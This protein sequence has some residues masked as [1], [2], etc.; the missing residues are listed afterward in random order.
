MQLF[1]VIPNKRRFLL[2]I[3][4]LN[5]YKE[6]LFFPITLMRNSL[7]GSTHGSLRSPRTLQSE[8]SVSRNAAM[9]TQK[10][11]GKD[12]QDSLVLIDAYEEAVSAGEQLQPENRV[13]YLTID[14]KSGAVAISRPEIR[15]VLDASGRVAT[16]DDDY[17]TVTIFHTDKEDDT[18][19][20]EVR[21]AL[22]RVVQVTKEKTDEKQYDLTASAEK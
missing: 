20:K 17:S 11:S 4:H 1:S 5:L 19:V 12:G 18:T 10:G 2:H 16:I 21:A 13:T 22:E 15:A 8:T 14:P 3:L 9:R 7:N 6:P